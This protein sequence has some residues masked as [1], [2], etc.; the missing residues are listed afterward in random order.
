M[1]LKIAKLVLTTQA[2]YIVYSSQTNEKSLLQQ[3]LVHIPNPDA[4]CT[5]REVRAFVV[6]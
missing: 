4:D 5:V 1:I 6:T 3:S 2:N